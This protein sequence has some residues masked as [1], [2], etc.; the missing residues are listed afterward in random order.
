[1][2]RSVI[3]TAVV[4]LLLESSAQIAFAQQHSSGRV[5]NPINLTLRTNTLAVWSGM[6]GV[7]RPPSSGTGQIIAGWAVS[8][9]GVL[10]L[11]LIPVC[12][13]SLVRTDTK[14]VCVGASVAV[15]VI[16]LGVGI[17][18]LIVGYNKRAANHE[19]KRRRGVAYHLSKFQFAAHSGGGAL[20]YRSEF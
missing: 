16:A 7:D 1:M 2:L 4:C 6:T 3:V 8:A 9:I 17:P 10:N 15:G 12:Y 14:D 18:L 11:A 20:V 13:S 5:L 19:W